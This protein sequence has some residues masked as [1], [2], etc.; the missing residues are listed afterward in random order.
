M[1]FPSLP[2]RPMPL[3]TIG[4]KKTGQE[5]TGSL[6]PDNPLKCL[7]YLETREEGKRLV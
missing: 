7:V 6:F 5:V 2:A 1:V 3:F 4:Q